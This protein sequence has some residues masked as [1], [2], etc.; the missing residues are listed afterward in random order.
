LNSP[1][2][3]YLQIFDLRIL[4]FLIVIDSFKDFRKVPKYNQPAPFTIYFL[5]LPTF[6]FLNPLARRPTFLNVRTGEVH[7]LHPNLHKVQPQ[8]EQQRNAAEQ[9]LQQRLLRLRTYAVGVREA[10]AAQQEGLYAKLKS[11]R[12]AAA[13]LG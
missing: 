2:L 4:P 7:T 10:A 5:V 11:T 9:S 8:L 6:S 13:R 1:E 12:E 3:D